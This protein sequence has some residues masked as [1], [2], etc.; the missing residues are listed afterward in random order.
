MNTLTHEQWYAIHVRTRFARSAALAIEEKG[1]DVF[2]PTCKE[3][4]PWSLKQTSLDQPLFPGYMFCRLDTQKRLLPILTT[5]GVISI[6]SAGKTPVP[7]PDHE[8]DAIKSVLRSGLPVTA[9]PEIVSGARVVIQNGP[10]SGIEGVIAMVARSCRLI[11][12][13]ELLCRSVMVEIDR[14]WARPV[15]NISIRRPPQGYRAIANTAA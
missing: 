14:E 2:H 13:V 10:L 6:V 4:R 11:V 12:S 7:V 3:E 8:V 15:E 1:Y 5:P 9:C